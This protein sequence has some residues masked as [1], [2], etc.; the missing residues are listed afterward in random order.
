M[1]VHNVYFTLNDPTPARQQQLVAACHRYLKDHPG[2]VLYAAGTLAE[3][4]E[5]P[6]NDRD[7]HVGLH[8]VFTDR[9]AHDDYQ[10][11]ESHQRFIAENKAD[12]AKVRVFD[13]IAAAE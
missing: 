3:G 4:L 13:S 11:S 1:L 2:I 6:V 8:V 9:Q 7:F 5:R 10:V 12:W